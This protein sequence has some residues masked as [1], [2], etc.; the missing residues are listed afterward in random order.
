MSYF[1]YILRCADDTLY[2]GITTDVE[3]RVFEH[4]HSEKGAKYTRMRRPVEL[5]Y[6][7]KYASRSEAC[8][9]EYSIKQLT[10]EEKESLLS[11]NNPW[12]NLSGL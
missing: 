9:R 5:V 10:R 4:N 7:E 12:G 2:T 8:K 1:T 11:G 3:R 6:N